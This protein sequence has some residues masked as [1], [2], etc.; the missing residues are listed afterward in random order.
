MTRESLKPLRITKVFASSSPTNALSIPS[1]SSFN[2]Q[3]WNTN[4]QQSQ[5]NEVVK[6]GMTTTRTTLH[7][8]R[9]LNSRESIPSIFFFTSFLL[10]INTLLLQITCLR[11]ARDDTWR[12][13]RPLTCYACSNKLNQRANINQT[14]Y[15]FFLFLRIQ[16]SCVGH[17]ID[18]GFFFYKFTIIIHYYKIIKIYI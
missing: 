6:R 12:T 2:A 15:S 18:K 9:M 14:D 5:R 11:S 1:C 10:T 4:C 3:T 16:E 13:N 17:Q 7:V 8:D